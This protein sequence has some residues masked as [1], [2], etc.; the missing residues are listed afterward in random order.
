M[1]VAALSLATAVFFGYAAYRLYKDLQPFQ[2]HY[3]PGPLPWAVMDARTGVVRVSYS[4]KEAAKNRAAVLNLT[5]G[6]SK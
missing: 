4:N 2:V 5:E 6:R 1:F 3:F